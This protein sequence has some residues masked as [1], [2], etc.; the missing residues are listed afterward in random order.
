MTGALDGIAVVDFTEYIAGPYCTMLLA[1]MGAGVTKVERPQGDAWRHTAPVAPYEARGYLGVNRGKRSIALD[2]EQAEGREVAHRLCRGADVA[3]FNY[4]PGV[5]TSLGLGYEA[6]AAVNPHLVYCE[7]TAFGHDGPYAG[8]PGFDILSQAA[9]GM[10]LY[11]NKLERGVPSYI[12]TVAV[13]DL[14]AAL[15]MAF[16]IVNAL[17][18]RTASGRGQRIDTSLFASGLAAQYRPLLSVEAVDRAVRDGFLS[19]LA[20]LRGGGG[21][22]GHAAA[23]QL[24][25]QYIPGRGRNN[26]YRV[27]ETKDALIA[28]GCLQNRQRRGL[29]DALGV[30]DATVDGA[31][32]DWFSEDVRAAHHRLTAAMEAAF[33]ARTTAAW[34]ALLDAHDVP[35]GAVK[36]P[37]EIFE[38]EH[39]I[40]SGLMI[41]LEHEVL[42]TLRMPAPPL[43]MS[44]T[45][46]AV[47]SAPP[48][49][50]AHSAEVLREL[51][52]DAATVARMFDA[53]VV[54]SRE[55]LLRA[56]AATTEEEG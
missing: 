53:G 15:F 8:R 51:G 43:R 41:D 30:D 24:R 27:Y 5:A 17:Y 4:R 18:A 3:V 50:G 52:Y 55:R 46:P 25:H 48:T 26:Y 6:L 14:T 9:T 42:G 40:A 19:A 56:D 7:N 47:R 1:D 11:E 16:A 34:L 39:A 54:T 2:M 13:A 38:D 44:G 23:V 12:A 31:T 20:D 36:F 33:R 32:Y 21:E 28:I 10:I 37:E 22:G 49:L 45:P 29:R 35:C